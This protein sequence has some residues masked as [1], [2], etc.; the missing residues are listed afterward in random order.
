MTPT[1]RPCWLAAL[2]VSVAPTLPDLRLGW[3]APLPEM[4]RRDEQTPDLESPPTTTAALASRKTQSE[5][6]S[7]QGQVS[8]LGWRRL[9]SV[10]VEPTQVLRWECMFMFVGANSSLRSFLPVFRVL[11]TPCFST[12]LPQMRYSNIIVGFFPDTLSL[13]G[14]EDLVALS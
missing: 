11:L 9:D 2:V 4:E 7:R 10:W 13:S 12:P 5:D 8:P 1:L 3:G 14:G 6:G